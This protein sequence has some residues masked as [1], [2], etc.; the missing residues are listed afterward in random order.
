MTLF[1]VILRFIMKRNFAVIFE[2]NFW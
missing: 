1:N 2:T